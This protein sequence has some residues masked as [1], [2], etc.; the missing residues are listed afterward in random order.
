[1]KIVGGAEDGCG[2]ALSRRYSEAV[3]ELVKSKLTG[4]TYEIVEEKATAGEVISLM[5][6]LRQSV[7]AAG[8]RTA[9]V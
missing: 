7:E 3:L 1:M 6:A 4:E 2:V 5:D 8:P 9:P